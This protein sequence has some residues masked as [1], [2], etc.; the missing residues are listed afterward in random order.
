MIDINKLHETIKFTC[1]YDHQEK[2]TTFLD[3]KVSI[4]N[5]YLVTDLYRKPTDR[6]QYL[7]PSSNHPNHIFKNVPYSLAL[8]LIRICSNKETL[9]RRLSELRE[10]LLTRN[11]NKNVVNAAIEKASKLNRTEVL[12]K[13]E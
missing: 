8:R 9:G 6:I 1:S 5:N 10:I 3:T 2:S 12:K 13:V 11:Y 7:L 4:R